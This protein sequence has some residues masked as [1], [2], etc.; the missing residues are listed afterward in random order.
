MIYLKQNVEKGPITQLRTKE[1][2]ALQSG[3]KKSRGGKSL[4]EITPEGQI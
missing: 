4:P 3:K 1:E 2:T